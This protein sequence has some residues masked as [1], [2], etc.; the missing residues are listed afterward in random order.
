MLGFWNRKKRAEQTADLNEVKH[1][2]V[3]EIVADKTARKEIK[4]QALQANSQLQS[5][6]A[7]NPFT[8]KVYLSMGGEYPPRKRRKN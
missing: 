8:I 1:D 6:L 2:A 5:L 7:D 4:S 3:V